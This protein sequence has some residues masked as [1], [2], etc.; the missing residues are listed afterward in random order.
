[1]SPFRDPFSDPSTWTGYFSSLSHHLLW[2]NY[3]RLHFSFI[4]LLCFV[5]D[6]WTVN[7]VN[8]V[9][10]PLYHHASCVECCLAHSRY[11]TNRCWDERTKECMMVSTHS[12]GLC[13]T[14]QASNTWPWEI[15]SRHYHL[16]LFIAWHTVKQHSPGNKMGKYYQ[17][18]SKMLKSPTQYTSFIH[19]KAVYF[20]PFSSPPLWPKCRHFLFSCLYSY[21]CMKYFFSKSRE[22]EP[23]KYYVFPCLERFNYSLLIIG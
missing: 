8:P 5:C 14:R 4:H 10:S 6:P 20:P 2:R 21:C 15:I 22:D 12:V 19:L 17:E 1:M 3:L 23:L 9:S 7:S 18:L 11:S 13:R 16:L